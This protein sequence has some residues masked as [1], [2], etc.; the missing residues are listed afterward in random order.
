MA[1]TICGN[2]G[3]RNAVPKVPQWPKIHERP[4]S[5]RV[6]Y[7]DGVVQLTYLRLWSQVLETS[8]FEKVP[9]IY[10][11]IVWPHYLTNLM[12]YQLLCFYKSSIL[13]LGAHDSTYFI[14]LF[15][16]LRQLEQFLGTPYQISSKI[17]FP[18]KD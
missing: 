4:H 5:S 12:I 18:E 17:A 16:P 10:P 15:M 6:R 13:I 1:H 9:P 11:L 7:N 2:S 3:S 8:Q 14:L